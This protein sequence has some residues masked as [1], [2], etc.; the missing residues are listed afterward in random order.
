MESVLLSGLSAANADED[1]SGSYSGGY[2]GHSGYGNDRSS[3]HSGS[4]GGG[5]HAG[6]YSGHSGYSDNEQCCPL[7]VD[8]LCLAAILGAIAG[9]TVLLQRVFMVELCMVDGAA[10][11]LFVANC[12]GRRKRSNFDWPWWLGPLGKCYDLIFHVG[13]AHFV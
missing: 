1:S 6:G 7:V 13:V 9:A 3:G 12:R 8:A 5:G 11:T 2:G 10:V 4:G